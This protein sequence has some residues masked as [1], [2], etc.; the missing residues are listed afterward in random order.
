MEKTKVKLREQELKSL[1]YMLDDLQS[2]NDKQHYNY[3][4]IES[5][6]GLFNRTLN[7]A[8]QQEVKDACDGFD[9]NIYKTRTYLNALKNIL[10]EK[11]CV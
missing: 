2:F 10:N 1:I 6:R 5:K 11:Y 3:R 7:A 4:M 8:D 9:S